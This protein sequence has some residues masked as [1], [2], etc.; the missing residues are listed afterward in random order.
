[1]NVKIVKIFY[2]IIGCSLVLFWM[3]LILTPYMA[4]CCKHAILLTPNKAV[5][6]S[7]L[8]AIP[9]MEYS[10][11]EVRNCRCRSSVP[12]AR[13]PHTHAHYPTLRAIALVRG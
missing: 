4:V 7:F 12:L 1:M 6:R 3:V 2:Y 11:P 13:I 5:D 10:V 9:M 8:G